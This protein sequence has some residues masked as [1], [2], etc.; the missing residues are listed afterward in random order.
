MT[1]PKRRDRPLVPEGYGV[2]ESSDGLLDWAT[3]E[4]RL[5][6]ELHYWMATTRPDG[7]PH[8]VPRW[9]VWIDGALYYDGSP[10][11]VHAVNARANAACTLH[12]GDGREAITIDGTT[13]AST[14]VA[15]GGGQL[16]ERVAAE[17]GRKYGDLGYRPEADA[18]SGPDAGGLMVFTPRKALAWFDF[19]TDLTRFQF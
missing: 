1:S 12:L 7:R 2:P 17:I 19:P 8:V 4:A 18:W 9:G 6:A 15:G 14:P 16:G 10:E 5:V 13:A 11:T 3:I